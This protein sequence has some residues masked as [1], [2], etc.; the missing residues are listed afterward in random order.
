M[1]GKVTHQEQR[2]TGC[3]DSQTE[4]MRGRGENCKA[5]ENQGKA[6]KLVLLRNSQQNV[7]EYCMLLNNTAYLQP[8]NANSRQL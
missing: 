5:N 4:L 7:S 3:E 1:V 6:D 2:A 8:R